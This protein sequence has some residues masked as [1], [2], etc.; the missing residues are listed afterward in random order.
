[1]GQKSFLVVSQCFHAARAVFL[2]RAFGLDVIGYCAEDPPGHATVSARLR[3]YGARCKA[4]LDVTVLGTQPQYPG[5]P[6]P[7]KPNSSAKR[8]TDR[9]PD[10][11][12]S[13]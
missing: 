12:L 6:A 3:E 10:K 5:A 13:D 4:V 7:I 2:A 9:A 11:G 1:M 8:E